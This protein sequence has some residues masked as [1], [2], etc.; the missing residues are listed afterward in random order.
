MN[1]KYRYRYKTIRD[2]NAIPT[3]IN[4]I[5]IREVDWDKLNQVIDK[6]KGKIEIPGVEIECVEVRTGKPVEVVYYE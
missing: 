3:H 2:P 5:C 4:G 6:C 1:K